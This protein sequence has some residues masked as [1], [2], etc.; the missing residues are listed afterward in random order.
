MAEWLELLRESAETTRVCSN[1]LC[2]ISRVLMRVGL[3]N[4]ATEIM[5]IAYCLDK[6]E[7]DI[8][9]AANLKASSD[10]QDATNMTGA[11]LNAVIG[12]A[13]IPKGLQK[14]KLGVKK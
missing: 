10:A 14:G 3:T 12:G 13:I 8:M 6:T 11:V 5:D 1:E 7:S 9:K 2:E 4:L